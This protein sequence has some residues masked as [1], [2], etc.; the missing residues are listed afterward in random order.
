MKKVCFLFILGTVLLPSCFSQNMI[1]LGGEYNIFKP[2]FWGAGAGFNTKLFNEYIQNDL[3]V[4]FGGIR[5][6]DA[7]NDN[8]EP[9]GNPFKSV[10][11]IK[12]NFYFSLDG[13]WLGLRAG[14]F[15]SLG[16]YGIPKFPTV[17]DLFFNPGGF[18][19]ICIL[20]KSQVSVTLDI[21]PGYS[22]AFRLGEG[23]ALNDSGFSLSLSLGIRFNI[24]KL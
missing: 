8:T 9:G 2:E 17:Y 21:C 5:V 11:Y 10:F 4:N 22:A 7:Q 14:I 19:G 18:A 6:K 16:V 12:D 24:D 20:P 23:M 1:I 15:A 13:K 3:T